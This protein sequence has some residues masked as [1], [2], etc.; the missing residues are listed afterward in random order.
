VSLAVPTSRAQLDHVANGIM[1]GVH[2][3]FPAE[4]DKDE[5]PIAHKKLK[6]GDGRWM[7]R[8]DLLGFDFDGEQHTIAVNEE[9]RAVLVTTLKGWT[10]ASR[11]AHCGVP[12]DE[13][14]STMEKVRHAFT[15]IP[16][17]R[18]LLSPY[19]KVLS[20]E[21]KFVFLHRNK[22]LLSAV[23]DCRTM[24]KEALAAP[25]PCRE[26]VSRWPSFV[27]VK[28][29]SAHGV[30]GVI[31][32]EGLACPPTVF[33]L[34][35]PADIKADLVTRENPAGRLTNSDLECAGLVL[36]WLVMEAVLPLA[37]LRVAHV[38]L[39]S[40]NQPTVSW[41][42]RFAARGSLVADQ[43]L[44]IL[45]LRLRKARVSPLT[46]MHIAGK[47]NQMTDVPSRSWGSNPAW[48]CAS[49]DELLTMFNALFPLPSKNSW[50]V[51]QPSSAIATKLISVLRMKHFEMAEW[52]RLP[53]LGRNTTPIGSTTSSL[54]NWSLTFRTQDTSNSSAPSQGLQQGFDLGATEQEEKCR[55][56]RRLARSRPLARRSV[57]CGEQIPPN[58]RGQKNSRPA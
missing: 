7:L 56:E 38:A 12:F 42:E 53:K 11:D 17:G 46:T 6:K 32:G 10:R 25:T 19:N 15:A 16:A 14:R 4:D 26:L 37:S 51:F 55:L 39:F 35:W 29:A 28:D 52:R 54:F 41:V 27:G 2:E 9:R 34:E 48:K 40:D 49:H 20:K 5:D 1:H 13:F 24:L 23:K 45:A 44:R 21:P 31:F 36:L 30:G 33:R 57:W 22:K 3:V 18:G 50:T 47:R 58:S 8:K 43:L